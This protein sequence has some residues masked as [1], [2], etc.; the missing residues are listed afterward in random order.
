MS[1]ISRFNNKKSQPD[2]SANT[3]NYSSVG[4]IKAG[5]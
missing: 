2:K 3:R 5:S 1:F 4:P